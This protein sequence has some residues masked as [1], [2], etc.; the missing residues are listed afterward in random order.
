MQGTI[1]APS[2]ASPSSADNDIPTDGPAYETPLGKLM[3]PDYSAS[4][5]AEDTKW[6]KRVYLYVGRYQ[7]MTGEVKKLPM[8]LAVVRRRETRPSESE[9]EDANANA[10]TEE[11]ELVEIVKYKLVFK[12]RPEPVDNS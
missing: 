7:R 3:F 5:P 9:S 6:M 11:L 12:N 1:N 10:N 2:D 8:P 4:T